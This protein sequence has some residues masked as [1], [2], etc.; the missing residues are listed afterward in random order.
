MIPYNVCMIVGVPEHEEY[1][2]AS[3]GGT[4]S[5][6]TFLHLAVKWYIQFCRHWI[7]GRNWRGCSPGEDWELNQLK[8][9]Q[10]SKRRLNQR[11]RHGDR[12][13][14]FRTVIELQTRT[15]TKI[16]PRHSDQAHQNAPPNTRKRDWY[17]RHSNGAM[18]R[19]LTLSNRCRKDLKARAQVWIQVIQNDR[20][21]LSIG[22]A[23]YLRLGTLHR[24]WPLLSLWDHERYAE[25]C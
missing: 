10:D 6:S 14:N 18:N 25:R 7:G 24:S 22:R 9:G 13:D 4:S 5:S 19:E 8:I 2:W 20:P 16:L 1:H 11:Q 12:N 17:E 3:D 15:K 23:W 21:L